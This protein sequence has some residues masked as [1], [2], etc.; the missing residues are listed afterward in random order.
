MA[1]AAGIG[2]LTRPLTSAYVARI[3][4]QTFDTC[5]VDQSNQLS[6]S[7]SL[8]AILLVYAKINEKSSIAQKPVPSREELIAIVNRYDTDGSGELNRAEF[9]AMMKELV[10]ELSA[11]AAARLVESFIVVPIAVFALT[12]LK[13][14]KKVPGPILGASVKFA[15]KKAGL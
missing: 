1:L 7:E 8:V 2:R 5:D 4:D 6:H 9:R 10:G 13:P 3:L 11:G 12:R 15:L 14:I